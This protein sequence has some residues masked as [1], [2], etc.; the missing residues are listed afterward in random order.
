MGP[1]KSSVIGLLCFINVISITNLQGVCPLTSTNL[2]PFYQF[3][4]YSS[5]ADKM[6]LSRELL[7]L[8]F[9][10]ETTF[11][12]LDNFTIMQIVLF[13]C[14]VINHLGQIPW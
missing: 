11:L 2:K 14:F 3:N 1:V 5:S 9:F 7:D 12:S 4:K 10:L 8:F 6:A 13:K